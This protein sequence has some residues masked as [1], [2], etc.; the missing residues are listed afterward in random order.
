MERISA[1][2]RIREELKRL[3]DDGDGGGDAGSELVRLAA[4]LI[5]EQALEGEAADGLGRVT[6]VW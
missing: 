2:E 1:S 3:M 4:Q 5:I 6:N